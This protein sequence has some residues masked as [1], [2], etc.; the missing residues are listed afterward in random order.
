MKLSIELENLKKQKI[1]N[2]SFSKQISVYKNFKKKLNDSGI[3]PQ[4]DTYDVELMDKVYH[5]I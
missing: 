3:K 4:K 5:K 1:L 2:K